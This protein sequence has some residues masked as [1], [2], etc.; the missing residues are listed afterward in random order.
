[1]S[2]TLQELRPQPASLPNGGPQNAETIGIT[3]PVL[4]SSTQTFLAIPV[5]A[6]IALAIHF[7]LPKKEIVLTSN[8]YQS[9]LFVILG[10]GLLLA[11]LYPF[12]PRLRNWMRRMCP[13]LG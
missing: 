9:L 6:G 7:F 2:A 1:M 8:Y 4:K 5:G 12:V 11:I 3:P 10:V 13:I